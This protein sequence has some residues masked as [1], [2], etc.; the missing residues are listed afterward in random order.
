MCI[1]LVALKPQGVSDLKALCGN[2]RHGAVSP[3]AKAGREAQGSPCDDVEDSLCI[4]RHNGRISEFPFTGGIT[5]R[6]QHELYHL[7]MQ[8]RLSHILKVIYGKKKAGICS[9]SVR[10]EGMS[11]AGHVWGQQTAVRCAVGV[12]DEYFVDFF[13]PLVKNCSKFFFFD[14]K[15]CLLLY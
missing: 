8:M 13:L 3:K 7:V 14:S 12:T 1:S 4:S 15:D 5:W 9:E 11:G 10:G 6:R 2:K